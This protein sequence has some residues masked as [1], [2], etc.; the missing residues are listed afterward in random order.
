MY[1][2]GNPVWRCVLVNYKLQFI[3]NHG[4]FF[5][6]ALPP[7]DTISMTIFYK[8]FLVLGPKIFIAHVGTGN[9]RSYIMNSLSRLNLLYQ[10]FWY[11]NYWSLLSRGRAMEARRRSRT[12]CDDLIE[13]VFSPG[14]PF[15]QSSKCLIHLNNLL[16]HTFFSSHRSLTLALIL[17][18]VL[19]AMTRGSQ[20]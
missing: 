1:I 12:Q 3:H 6:H 17:R 5:L 19:R 15:I 11:I 9:K 18:G 8:C 20:Q 16:I 4:I 14:R 7:F 2:I 13:S 10:I